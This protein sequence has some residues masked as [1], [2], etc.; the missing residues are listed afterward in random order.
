LLSYINQHLADNG[1]FFLLLPAKR[2]REI[3]LLLQEERLLVQQKVLVQQTLE[4]PPFRVMIQG[5]RIKTHECLEYNMSVKNG[6][7]EYTAAFVAL[8]RDYYLYL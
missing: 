7:G 1:T 4:H 6:S 5:C 3:I 8:L 2:E